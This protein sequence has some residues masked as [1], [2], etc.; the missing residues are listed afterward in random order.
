MGS[1]RIDERILPG[2]VNLNVSLPLHRP[3]NLNLNRVD[4]EVPGPDR[5]S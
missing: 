5:E 1:S 3:L 2:I 4:A